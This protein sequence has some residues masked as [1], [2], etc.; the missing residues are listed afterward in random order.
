V[1]A[2]STCY[3]GGGLLHAIMAHAD[4]ARLVLVLVSTVGIA[5]ATHETEN[6]PKEAF[7]AF[8]R[9]GHSFTIS[10]IVTGSLVVCS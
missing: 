8:T 5:T 4:A 7:G 6:C 9:N 3:V 10:C 1:A 2:T